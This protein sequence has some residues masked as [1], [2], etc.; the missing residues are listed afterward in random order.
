MNELYLGGVIEGGEIQSK[1]ELDSGRLRTHAVVVGMTGSGKTGLCLVMLEELAQAGV[2]VIAIDPKGDL[3]NLALLFPSLRGEDFAPWIEGDDPEKVAQGWREGLQRWGLGPE[4]LERL[5]S[6][7]DLRVFTP[8][9]RAGRPVN[10]LDTFRLPSGKMADDPDARATLVSACVTGLLGLVGRRA[11][12]IRDP[13][14]IVLSRILSDAWTAKEDPGIEEIILRLV[15]PPF[16]KVG[17][18]PLDRFSLRMTAWTW[19]WPSTEFSRRRPSPPGPM[20]L[21]SMWT[22]CSPCPRTLVAARV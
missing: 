12:P 1:L 16:A 4:Q 7:M 14:H 19:P 22:R 18:F 8:G 15:D 6:G 20:A 3:G 11:D 17:V 9:S 13:A 5:R 10:L 21:P 2:P